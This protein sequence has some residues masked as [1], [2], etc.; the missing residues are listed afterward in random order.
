MSDDAMFWFTLGYVACFVCE[1][2]I[3]PLIRRRRL[4]GG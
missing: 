3:V 2:F 1:R 4:G